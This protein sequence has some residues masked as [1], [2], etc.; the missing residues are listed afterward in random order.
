MLIAW[1]TNPNGFIGEKQHQ[2]QSSSKTQDASNFN[3]W[4]QEK[5]HTSLTNLVSQAGSWA[6]D[7][8][9]L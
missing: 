8:I 4:T 2:T 5:N 1:F 6:F 9:E 3:D 7:V